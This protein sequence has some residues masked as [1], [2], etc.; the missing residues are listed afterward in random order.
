MD[1]NHFHK[2][3][4]VPSYPNVLVWVEDLHTGKYKI[5]AVWLSEQG[6]QISFYMVVEKDK[7]EYV[8]DN[9]FSVDSLAKDIP[10]LTERYYMEEVHEPSHIID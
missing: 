8:F 2:T 9:V 4:D 3:V 1:H 10:V 5:H 7:L 6:D